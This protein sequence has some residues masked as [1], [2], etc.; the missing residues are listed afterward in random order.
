MATHATGVETKIPEQ[1]RRLSTVFEIARI[2]ATDYDL[3]TVLSQFL[4][5]LTDTL[6][7]AEAGVL[8]LYDRSDERLTV[9]AAKGY[10]AASLEEIRLAPGEAMCGKTFQ[11]GQIQ[12]YPNQEAIATAKR[13]LTPA[14][15][16]AIRAAI[17]SAE[18]P[19]SAICIPLFTNQTTVGVLML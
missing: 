14:N 5:C 16:K 17:A 9:R 6:E 13:T 2:L 19:L 3:E 15:R 11:T 4:S 7:I 12:L 1:D 8:L 10:Y 18:S